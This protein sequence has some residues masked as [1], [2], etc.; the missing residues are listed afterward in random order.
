MREPERQPR[1]NS[2]AGRCCGDENDECA[3]PCSSAR[4]NQDLVC[5]SRLQQSW[6]DGDGSNKNECRTGTLSP[7]S[8]GVESLCSGPTTEPVVDTNA[9]E[10][11]TSR[12]FYK[13]LGKRC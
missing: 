7:F 13:I 12:G 9:V 10:R 6:S 1:K 2:P 5:E 11:Q 3:W 4:S 8:C